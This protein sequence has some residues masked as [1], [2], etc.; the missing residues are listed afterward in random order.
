MKK[1]VPPSKRIFRRLILLISNQ[2][3]N[4]LIYVASGIAF[5][6]VDVSVFRSSAIL[7]DHTVKNDLPA[8]EAVAVQMG[9]LAVLLG[10]V[11]FFKRRLKAKYYEGM[12]AHV[13]MTAVKDLGNMR[14]E[15]LDK[16]HSGD[17]LT[18]IQKDIDDVIIGLG[19][20]TDDWLLEI[21]GLLVAVSYMLYVNPRITLL[22]FAITPVLMGIQM[23][24]SKPIQPLRKKVMDAKGELTHCAQDA[25]GGLS[26]IKS[27]VLEDE[28]DARY[29]KKQQKFARRQIKSML[30]MVLTEL[31]GILLG[32]TPQI[33]LFTV[34]VLESVAGRLELSGFIL[35]LTL[36]NRI[37][38]PI[39]MVGQR[40]AT[41]KST[42]ASGERMFELLDSPLERK[43]GLPVP[44][45][46]SNEIIAL[47]D[48]HFDYGDDI[49]VLNGLSL[50]ICKGEN[51]ALVGPS[52]CGKST[53]LKLITG[54]FEPTSGSIYY[55]KV[56]I[57]GLNLEALRGELA[58]VSQDSHLYP[59]SLRINIEYGK[60]N[61]TDD[62]IQAACKAAGIWD[63]IATLPN[64]LDTPAGEMGSNLSGGQKQR[65]A[66][67]RAVLRDAKVLLLDEATAS[68]DV[69]TE[70]G[71][72]AALNCIS[73]GRTT[74]TVAH[75]LSTI[76]GADRIIVMDKGKA[77]ASGTHD[78]LMKNCELYKRL[79]S[80]STTE[81]AA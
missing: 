48:V 78:E 26:T 43:G 8:F 18:R 66:I 14:M 81:E 54:L 35:L 19:Q 6:L 10:V 61:A 4:W 11:A 69:N 29:A 65:I 53:V 60:D 49:A 37:M 72:Q 32:T 76:V 31:S 75:R 51:V 39:M 52:G 46:S 80:A 56:A 73:K 12:R 50:T 27:F 25:L 45:T 7:I 38:N 28:F 24:I 15:W 70:Q 30:F 34:C 20:A 77:V 5:I 2:W 22:S 79:Y 74:V 68:L 59:D 42:L 63:F 47:E 3:K 9:L 17:L 40:I 67:A 21:L 57:S 62:E 64:G 36:S 58:Y 71:V 41:L 1:Q 23:A 13:R 44:S 55:N 33:V 16:Q